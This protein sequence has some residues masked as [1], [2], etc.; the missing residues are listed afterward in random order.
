MAECDAPF[1]QGERLVFDL[2]HIG[3]VAGCVSWAKDNRIGVQ[4]DRAIDP[5]AV[6]KPVGTNPGKGIP[7]YVRYLGVKTPPL[8]RR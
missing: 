3:P 6:R 8:P 1:A 5:Q 4:F 2:R 7:L